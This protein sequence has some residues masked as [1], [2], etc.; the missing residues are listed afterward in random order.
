[1]FDVH[2]LLRITLFG[3]ATAAVFMCADQPAAAWG[4]ICPKFAQNRVWDPTGSLGGM[5]C[6]T[7][8][9][10]TGMMTSFCSQSPATC[11]YWYCIHN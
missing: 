6:T 1:M 2:R 7:T 5:C 3:A 9:N 11:G 10:M 8:N 4:S